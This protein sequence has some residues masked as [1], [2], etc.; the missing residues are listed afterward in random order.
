MQN[1]LSQLAALTVG[2]LVRI[3][4]SIL[5]A[6]LLAQALGPGGVGQWAM[7]LAATTLLHFSLLKWVQAPS[8]RFGREE[9]RS[10]Q[11][12][13]NTW[14]ARWPLIFFGV[15]ISAMLLIFQPFS[16]LERLFNLPTTWWPLI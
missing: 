4:L 14:A 13:S 7:I 6:S 11:S 16:F 1:P 12:L 10:R 2:M 9:W 8:F 15:G 5:T 3:P